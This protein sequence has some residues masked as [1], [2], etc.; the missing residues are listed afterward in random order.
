MPPASG[1]ASPG[2]VI[3]EVSDRQRVLRVA[4]RWIGGIAR[5]ALRAEGIAAA[6]LGLMLVDDRRM[7]ALHEQWLGIPGPTDV[8][9]FDLAAGPAGR[10]LLRGDIVVSTETARREA[11]GFGWTPR[12]ELAYYVVHGILHLT[13]HDDLAPAGRRAMRARERAVMRACGLPPPP[14]ARGARR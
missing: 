9:T 7:A 10:G 12:R 13:G 6:E 3:V 4:P 1:R 8:I 14:R 2:A 5:R 11:G